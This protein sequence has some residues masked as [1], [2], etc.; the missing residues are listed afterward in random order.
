MKKLKVLLSVLLS[1]MLVLSLLVPVMADEPDF[2]ITI[3]NSSLN[4]TY[5]AYKILD[6]ESYV[7][8]DEGTIT[9]A[10]YYVDDTSPWLSVLQSA[11][12]YVSVDTQGFR[13]YV[14]WVNANNDD[15]TVQAFAKY[16]LSNKPSTVAADATGTGNGSSLVLDVADAGWYLVDT[17][18]GTLC[19]LNTTNPNVSIEEKNTLPTVDKDVKEGNVWGDAND[20]AIGDTVEFKTTI[21]AYK[22]AQNYVLHD[23]MDSSLTLDQNSIKVQVNG[24]DIA[25]N[26]YTVK[27][28]V[29]CTDDDAEDDAVC[30]FEIEFKQDYLDTITEHIE[31]VVLYNA[32]INENA[33]I[34]TDII[35]KTFLQYGD[36]SKT[37]ESTTTTKTHDFNLQKTDG[38]NNQISGAE[39]ILKKDGNKVNLVAL[40]KDNVITGYR[41]ATPEE[42]AKAGY[43]SPNIAV[44]LINIKGL[45]SGSYTLHEEVTPA[46]YNTLA[47]DPSFTIN[48]QGQVIYNSEIAA[49]DRV[50][51]VNTAGTLLPSTGGTGTKVLFTVGG[52]MMVVAFVLITSKRRMAAEK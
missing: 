11:T 30:T 35:N 31:I 38:T 44:G 32:V 49:N 20:G 4:E 47:S 15:D 6:I 39:F 43:K 7:T 13:K 27:S 22:G 23:T 50:I 41:V 42:I 8:N 10:V 46:G 14:T 9:T 37:T 24:N 33:V 26:Y 34:D 1:A 40:L 28:N 52:I 3:T 36:D 29:E 16:L 25:K 17:S 2:K 51:V 45:D 18:L 5:N 21:D 12:A 19:N 48:E